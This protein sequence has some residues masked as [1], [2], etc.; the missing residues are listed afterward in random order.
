MRKTIRNFFISDTLEPSTA[1]ILFMLLLALIIGVCIF[2]G[3]DF[4]IKEA[5]IIE[6]GA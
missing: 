5:G 3:I 4:F 2:A 6:R 1:W